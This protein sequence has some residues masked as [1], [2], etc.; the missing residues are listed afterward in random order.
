MAAGQVI[1]KIGCTGRCTGPHLH[2][3]IR[4]NGRALNPL[5][6]SLVDTLPAPAPK[7]VVAAKPAAVSKVPQTATS[8][9]TVVHST[10]IVEDPN[11]QT[12]KTIVDTLRNGQ[13]V[14]RIE[15]TTTVEGSQV[16]RVQKT[17][18]LVDGALKLTAETREVVDAVKSSE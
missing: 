9:E 17:Y 7:A 15:V 6:V 5:S 4:L 18:E 8:A 16:V 3:E 12:V 14:K 1:A 13:V 10:M 11:G 2:F